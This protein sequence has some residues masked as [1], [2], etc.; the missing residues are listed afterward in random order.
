MYEDVWL[1]FAFLGTT[2]FT[3][4]DSRLRF[5]INDVQYYYGFHYFYGE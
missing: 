3:I 4:H 5:T 1:S 2:S